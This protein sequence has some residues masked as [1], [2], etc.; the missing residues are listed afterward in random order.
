[1]PLRA[2]GADVWVR[3]VLPAINLDGIQI[4]TQSLSKD[5]SMIFGLT[6]GQCGVC[7]ALDTP[8]D[9]QVCRN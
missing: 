8:H 1:M 4:L 6:H 5:C 7:W 2:T 3:Y 9:A